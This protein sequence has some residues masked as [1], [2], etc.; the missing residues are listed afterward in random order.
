LC[1]RSSKTYHRNKRGDQFD[2]GIRVFHDYREMDQA[3]LSWWD[4]MQFIRGRRR[5]QVAWIHPRHAYQNLIENEAMA[6]TER[7]YDQIDGGLFSNETTIYRAVG[8]IRKKIIGHETK[9]MPGQREWL[10]AVSAEEARL[11]L[12]GRYTVYP[13]RTVEMLTWCRFVTICAPMEV[14]NPEELRVVAD[15]VHRLLASETTLTK[16]FPGYVYTREKWLAEGLVKGSA[17]RQ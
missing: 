17:P 6:V 14:R 8:R 13:S 7:L 4:D 10:D 15:L 1:R 12:E 11:S 2:H 16:E 9:P 5:I 3:G